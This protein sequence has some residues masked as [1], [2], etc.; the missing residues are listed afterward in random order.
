MQAIADQAGNDAMKV[1]TDLSLGPGDLVLTGLNTV[2]DAGI[3]TQLAAIRE[4]LA[5][6]GD[7]T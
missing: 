7:V 4:S 5:H 6:P 1:E 2:I 3:D